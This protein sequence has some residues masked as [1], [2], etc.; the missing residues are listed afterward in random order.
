MPSVQFGLSSYERGRGDLP[1][2]PVINMFAEEAPTEDRGVVLQSRPGLSDRSADMGTGPVEALFKRDLVLDTALFG[3]SGGTLYSGATAI[4]A[5]SGNG[6]VSMAGYSTNLFVT[7]GA[8]LWGYDGTTLAEISLPDSFSAVKV[9]V[10]AS[11]AVVIRK[12]TGKLYWSDALEDDIESLDFTT[13]ENQ[14]DR[15]LDLLFIDDILVVFGAET[16]EFMPNTQDD[17]LPFQPLEG[18]VIEKGIK[19]TGCAVAIGSTFAWVTNTN[20]VCLGDESTIISNPGMEERIEAS[21]ECRLWTFT[22]GGIDFIALR[23][24]GETHAWSIRSRLWCQFI[25]YGQAN[26]IPQCFAG[27]VFG[28]SIDGRTLEWGAAHED[29]GGLLERRFRGG[30]PINSGGLSVNNTQIRVNVGQTPFLT[31]DYDEPTVEMRLSRDAGQTFGA[32]RA[33]GLGSQGNYRTR[34]QWRACGL[35]SQP[36]FLPEFRM[37]APVPFRVSDVLIN[38]PWGGR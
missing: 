25:S 5:I 33:V 38:E 17:D 21:T 9:I 15:A 30:F 6:P 16:V 24:D 7:A 11:R 13:A 4:G 20:Q 28:S 31:G 14:P 12:D 36:G 35:A 8:G 34:V 3:V 19:A 2:L 27:G 32:W 22:L 18:R 26:W 29:L 10:A 37:T 23:I 1:E